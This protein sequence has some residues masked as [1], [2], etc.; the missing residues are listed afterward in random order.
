MK[1]P[2]IARFEQLYLG[3]F[4]LGL[5]ATALSWRGNTERLAADPRTAS[6]SGW[7]VPAT[8]ALTIVIT[9]LLWYFIAR[10]G[11]VVAKWIAVI[12]IALGLLGGIGN[13]M[14]LLGG[15]S[16]NVPASLLSL[17]VT[18]MQVAAAVMLFRPDARLWFGE[19]PDVPEEPLA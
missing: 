3:G 16:P 13:L 8:T 12:F 19:T 17:V 18:L 5:V 14:T 11:S 10:R 7:F 15:H 9:L 6:V 1:P 2:S 4:A